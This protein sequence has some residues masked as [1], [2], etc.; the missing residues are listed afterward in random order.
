MT[1][2]ALR[3]YLP[4]DVR[5][6]AVV[7]SEYEDFG[8]KSPLRSP[9]ENRW[10]EPGAL[11]VTADGECV[12]DVAWYRPDW[13]PGE[14]SRAWGIGIGLLPAARGRGI[15]TWAQAELT[16]LIFLHTTANRVEASTDV[17]NRP[18]QR[19]LEKAGFT[20]EGV[21]RG[22]QWRLGEWHDMVQFSRLRHDVAV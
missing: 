5:L 11:V 19:S 15:G 9:P 16:R 8:I 4:E 21:M 14:G 3:A 20:R 1:T 6:L 7:T 2:L 18:E 10:D 17:T 22:A 13:G 12:G